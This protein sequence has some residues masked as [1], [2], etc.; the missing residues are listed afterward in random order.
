MLLKWLNNTSVTGELTIN[1]VQ[2]CS[3]FN[4]ILIKEFSNS[5]Y[6]LSKVSTSVI[7]YIQVPGPNFAAYD[8]KDFKYVK[9]SEFSN[10]V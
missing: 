1:V 7:A 6:N 10:F 2:C 3:T 5:Y 8:C 9:S 4:P